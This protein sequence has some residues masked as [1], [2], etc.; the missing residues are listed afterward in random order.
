MII[1]LTLVYMSLGW[2][3]HIIIIIVLGDMFVPQTWHVLD[4]LVGRFNTFNIVVLAIELFFF[5]VF[6]M[7]NGF[8]LV[9]GPI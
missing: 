9:F 1:S 4:V 2:L 8:P 6:L 7:I 3:Y 5:I